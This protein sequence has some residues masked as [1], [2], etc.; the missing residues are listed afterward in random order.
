MKRLLVG[1]ALMICAA[2]LSLADSCCEG[3]KKQL[4]TGKP[5]SGDPEPP[6]A[7][8]APPVKSQWKGNTYIHVA[9]NCV[10]RVTYLFKG[11]RSEGQDGALLLNNK[12]VAP[13]DPGQLISTPLGKIKHYGTRRR[14][15]WDITGWNFADRRHIMS[16]DQLPKPEPDKNEAKK[17]GGKS[18]L[19]FFSGRKSVVKIED[20]EEGEE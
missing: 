2:G 13:R 15:R 16:S 8:N 17:A 1:V 19:P 7:T 9:S 12:V 5:M 4:P 6:V 14:R 18:M 10:L 3:G 11:T 20:D